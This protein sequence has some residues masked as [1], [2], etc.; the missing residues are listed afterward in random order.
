LK[1][2]RSF[3]SDIGAS[4]D[5]ETITSAIIALAH[6]LQLQVIAEGVETAAQL[7]FLK[8]RACNEMQGYFF[9][10]PMPH[11]AIPALL[12]RTRAERRAIPV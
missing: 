12:Q 9:A 6:S 10:R 3:V 4:S 1:I 5:D 2:D 8:E 11:D 7:D